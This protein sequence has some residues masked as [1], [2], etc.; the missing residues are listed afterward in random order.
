MNGKPLIYYAIDNALQFDG[1]ESDIVVDTDDD[2]IA[3]I[4]AKKM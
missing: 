3:R 4:A 2:E 1:C